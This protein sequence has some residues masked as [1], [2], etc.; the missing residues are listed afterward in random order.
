MSTSPFLLPDH[1]D[2]PEILTD[3]AAHVLET[4]GVDRFSVA[5]MARWMKI[6]PAA[7]NNHYSRA[8]VLDLVAIHFSRRWLH[9][10]VGDPRWL[11]QPHPCPLR[12]PMTADERHGVVVLRAISELTR[13]ERVRGNPLPALRLAKLRDDEMELLGSRVTQLNP[14]DVYAPVADAELRGLTALLAGLR[15]A[16]AEDPPVL[17]WEAAREQFARAAIAVAGSGRDGPSRRSDQSPR[18]EPAA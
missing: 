7:I 3:A 12:L 11:Q 2:Y 1:R 16:L 5:A 9:W 15:S 17:S 4:T 14:T 6:T 8:R 10:S 18:N 13:G